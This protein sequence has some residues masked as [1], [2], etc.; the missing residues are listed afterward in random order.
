[1]VWAGESSVACPDIGGKK[2]LG[3]PSRTSRFLGCL[4]LLSSLASLGK[5]SRPDL[6]LI[7]RPPAVNGSESLEVN[8]VC[9]AI[10]P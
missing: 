9:D 5:G 7:L 10:T 8:N 4:I 6:S 3:F 1:M 2:F